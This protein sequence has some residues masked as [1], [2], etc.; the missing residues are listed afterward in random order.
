[1]RDKL[2]VENVLRQYRPVAPPSTL[3]ARIASSAT[4]RTVASLPHEERSIMKHHTITGGGGTQLHVVETGNTSGR[5]ILFIHGISQCWLTW[6][7]QLN[8]ELR[9]RYRLV[10]MDMR[11]HGL[12]EKPRDAYADAKLWADD[13]DAVLQALNLDRPVL[14]GW[15]YGP[16]VILDYVR[17]YGEGALGGITFVDGITKLG[18]EEAASVLTPEFLNLVP[19][20]FSADVEESTRSLRTLLR[21]CVAQEPA[22]EDLYLMLGYNV[23]VP[24]SV[25]E[26]LLSRSFDNDDLLPTLHKPVLI[27]HGDRDPI[28][29]PSVVDQHKASLPHAEVAMMPNAAHAPFWDDAPAFNGR[30]HTFCERLELRAVS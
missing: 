2:D 9:D 24:P 14:C 29:K 20:F 19:G 28:V 11:G 27:V 30:L 18:S 16:L 22:P 3:R 12:S 13:I 4:D 25:R 5:P 23:S 6:S 10:A 15:S 17:H 1:M 26:A 21:L 8:S 7:R